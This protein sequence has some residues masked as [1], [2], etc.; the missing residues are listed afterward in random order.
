MQLGLRNT[1]LDTRLHA[2]IAATRDKPR[3]HSRIRVAD[4]SPLNI[5]PTVDRPI[6]NTFHDENFVIYVLLPV[7]QDS[8][9]NLL[10]ERTS[11]YRNSRNAD[12]QHTAKT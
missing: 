5:V 1:I 7:Q 8:S 10:L 12:K 6:I 2:G 11:D 9:V 4:R 3:R